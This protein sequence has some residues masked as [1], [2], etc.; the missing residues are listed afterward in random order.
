VKIK[1]SLKLNTITDPYSGSVEVLERVSTD[2]K[3]LSLKLV[4]RFSKTIVNKD[5]G[6][7]LIETSSPTHKVSWAGVVSD[8]LAL[9]R[10]GL[11]KPILEYMT[12]MGYSKLLKY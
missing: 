11:A 1:G 5:M 10:N 3:F 6:I 8:P 7:S 9:A 2:L 4:S 12:E